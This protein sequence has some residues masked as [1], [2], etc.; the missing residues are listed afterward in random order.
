MN[1]GDSFHDELTELIDKYSGMEMTNAEA[2]GYLMYKVNEIM[3]P[4]DDDDI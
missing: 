3:I 1:I 2:V 4:L